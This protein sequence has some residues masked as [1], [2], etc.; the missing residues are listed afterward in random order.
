[1][2]G[3]RIA[4][5]SGRIG[6]VGRE[7]KVGAKAPKA[8][9][10]RPAK[11]A[12]APKV[13][14]EKRA[15]TRGRATSMIQLVGT[16][17][18]LPRLVMPVAV[19]SRWKKDVDWTAPRAAAKKASPIGKVKVGDAEGF[20]LDAALGAVG[21][22]PTASGGVFVGWIDATLSGTGQLPAAALASQIAAVTTRRWRRNGIRVTGRNYHAL[23]YQPLAAGMRGLEW[24]DVDLPA[25]EYDVDTVAPH[26][27]ALGK[28]AYVRL[29]RVGETA[30]A[31]DAY[32][33]SPAQRMQARELKQRARKLRWANTEGGPFLCVP[34]ELAKAWLGATGGDY[35]RACA[36]K[37]DAG[38]ITVGDGTGI[39]LG[40]PNSTTWIET[41]RGNGLITQA[42][43]S[44]SDEQVLE[45]ALETAAQA[46]WKPIGTLDVGS[47]K[48]RIQDA[49]STGASPEHG[50]VT[51]N[52]PR[53][54][55]RA[56][57]RRAESLGA[58]VSMVRLRRAR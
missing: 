56:E 21:W 37:S 27:T 49:C 4:R 11:P 54:T 31:P 10:E 6:I 38:L 14:L 55:Y 47:G 20:A 58:G 39:V 30:S 43:M 9:L 41:G 35:D 18:A 44:N 53:G 13:K 19:I 46:G 34:E 52:V 3:K 40:Y 50:K 28:L 16:Y 24:L 32:Q 33:P 36:V 25:G 17:S 42:I 45:L 48:L 12:K 7:T 51:F 5:R 29:T 22:V 2:T 1:M 23:A 26:K 8:K 57:Q 15:K